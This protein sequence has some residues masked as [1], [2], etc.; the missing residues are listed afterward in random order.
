MGAV[1]ILVGLAVLLPDNLSAQEPLPSDSLVSVE[2][3]DGTILRGTIVE[4][5][6]TIMVFLTI[7]GAE[8]RMLR[9]SI[10]SIRPIRGRVVDGVFQRFDPNYSRL[11][12]APTGRPLRKGDA[13]FSDFYVFFP[14]VAY[15]IS[16]H[17]S[18]MGGMSIIPGISLTQQLFYIAPRLGWRPSDN[19][20]VSVGAL[21][22]SVLE[23]DV[24]R[25]YRVR[26]GYV[27]RRGREL[28]RRYW[29]GL[30]EEFGYGF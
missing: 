18:I 4:Q 23:E 21:Y 10:V 11:L 25:R 20:A 7:G 19:V 16:D 8:V 24:L 15:G 2:L 29:S 1:L 30:H 17:L 6:E 12:F 27:W 14:G 5:D 22:A 26:R 28:H 13:Y 9:A 3:R